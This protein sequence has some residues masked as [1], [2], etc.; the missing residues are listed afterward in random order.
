[1]RQAPNLMP[2]LFSAPDE[3]VCAVQD[4]IRFSMQGKWADAARAMALAADAAPVGEW[5]DKAATAGHQLK[6]L[7]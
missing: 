1:M 2:L 4:A 5:G 3:C 7:A 6:A